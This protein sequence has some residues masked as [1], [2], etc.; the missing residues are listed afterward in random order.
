MDILKGLHKEFGWLIWGLVGI[1]LV[2]FFTGGTERPEAH[3]GQYIKPLAP[4][5]TGEI[6]GRYYAGKEQAQTR[7]TLDLPQSPAAIIK[8]TESGIK[9][10][11]DQSEEA[12][13]I[14]VTS[15]LA[16]K[17]SFDGIAGAKSSDPNKEYIRLLSSEHAKGSINVSGLLLGGNAFDSAAIIPK[18]VNFPLL[19]VTPAKTDVLLPPGGRALVTTGRSPVGMSIRVNMCSGYLDQFQDYTPGL[20]KNCPSAIDELKASG[21]YNDSA[22]RDLAEKIPRCRIYQGSLPKNISRAC[23]DFLAEKLNYN[24]CAIRHEKDKDFYKD[25]WRI[26]LDRESELWRNKDEII[27]L[28]DAKQNT[29]DAVTY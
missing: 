24:S 15:L 2:W 1:A 8:K 19:G 26:F 4:L 13:Q 23:V 16:K 29:I 5:D 6:Y 28:I 14:H 10:F 27:R 17:V 25:E 12:K 9:S 3:E 11:L 18:A 7:T 22:C 20:E 21:P